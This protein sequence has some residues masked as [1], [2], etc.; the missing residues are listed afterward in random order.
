VTAINMNTD[1]FE[2]GPNMHGELDQVKT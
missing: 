2:F 1:D